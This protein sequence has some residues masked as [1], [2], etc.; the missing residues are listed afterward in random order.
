MISKKICSFSLELEAYAIETYIDLLEFLTFWDIF[1]KFK[2][3]PLCGG[4]V[5]ASNLLD[6]RARRS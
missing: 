3:I 4:K 1:R 5:H 6:I 2:F